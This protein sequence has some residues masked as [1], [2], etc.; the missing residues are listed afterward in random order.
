MDKNK[1]LNIIR[2]NY[3]NQFKSLNYNKQNRYPVT[4][5]KNLFTQS[6]VEIN[7]R[8]TNKLIKEEYL[9][10]IITGL[11]LKDINEATY[12]N[13][14]NL[15]LN[16]YPNMNVIDFENTVKE[17]TK[18]TELNSNKIFEDNY[19][20]NQLQGILTGAQYGSKNIF[21][22]AISYSENRV[23]F[24]IFTPNIQLNIDQRS[25]PVRGRSPPPENQPVLNPTVAPNEIPLPPTVPTREALLNSEESRTPI[26]TPLG[27][28]ELNKLP[29]PVISTRRK[30][31]ETEAENT[32]KTP[33]TI[34]VQTKNIMQPTI[35]SEPKQQVKPV[36]GRS[37]SPDN[38]PNLNP[39][40]APNE[41]PLPPTIPT[42]EALLNSEESRTPIRTPLG[43]PELNKLPTPV[44]STRRK[45]SE[46]EAENTLKTPQ[47]IAVQT[48]NIM[49]PTIVSEPKQQAKLVKSRN[50][51]LEPSTISPI[52][53]PVS[54]VPVN[55]KPLISRT[56]NNT[57]VPQPISSTV[58]MLDQT[59]LPQ[60][61]ELRPQAP[62]GNTGIPQDKTGPTKIITNIDD[63]KR[64][65]LD[66]LQIYYRVA[67]AAEFRAKQNTDLIIEKDGKPSSEMPINLKLQNVIKSYENTTIE[68]DVISEQINIVNQITNL[69]DLKRIGPNAIRISDNAS[70]IAQ[71][72]AKNV[73][74][75]SKGELAGG[76][77]TN[78]EL[79]YNAITAL[80][81][82]DSLQSKN[83]KTLVTSLISD[84][85]II[86]NNKVIVD[87]PKIEEIFKI[88][89][90]S[91]F[92]SDQGISVTYDRMQKCIKNNFHKL[93]TNDKLNQYESELNLDSNDKVISNEF[94][95]RVKE[96]NK[97]INKNV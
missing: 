6:I 70:K 84:T 58:P 80:L 44:I 60:R 12:T 16:K 14:L 17:Y 83:F 96:I 11:N 77:S 78:D 95:T 10:A 62:V 42:R 2:H 75:L 93:L 94:N 1:I 19:L 48:K 8:K 76:D 38:Q 63:A 32:L 90:L 65:L 68:K 91:L 89:S 57:S 18:Q 34:A 56:S 61:R 85:I 27:L 28:P 88:I 97:I 86:K 9:D 71:E 24:P 47:T 92:C 53:I 21:D 35:V 81:I 23:E 67:K 31:S 72:E 69:D 64:S 3:V 5:D 52:S 39:T 74:K 49:Q 73:D 45:L 13:S 41:I 59:I 37:V 4:W 51:S 55:P 15:L 30:L 54:T 43:L 40:V 20:I 66:K 26:R 22:N 79:L 46:T 25:K 7:K 50:S 33:Q 87:V 29:T 82:K 36:R